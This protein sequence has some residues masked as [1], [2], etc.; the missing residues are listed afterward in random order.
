[1]ETRYPIYDL[2]DAALK[3]IDCKGFDFPGWIL[4]GSR[5]EVTELHEKHCL[6]LLSGNRRQHLSALFLLVALE[7]EV[8]FI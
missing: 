8:G 4:A 6:P 2:Q 5:G 7:T 1:M 3:I